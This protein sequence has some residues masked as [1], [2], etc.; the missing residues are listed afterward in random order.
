MKKHI[1]KMSFILL[2]L[3]CMTVFAFGTYAAENEIAGATIPV[4]V[5]VSGNEGIQEGDIPS[6][7]YR[8]Q[9]TALNDAPMPANDVLTIQGAGSSAF[10]ISY[11]EVGVYKYKVVQDASG[12]TGENSVCNNRGHY[13]ESVFYV[14][15]TV[16]N[17]AGGGYSV[18]VSAHKD[19]AEGTKSDIAY[20]NTYDPVAYESLTVK[21]TWTDHTSTRPD[22]IQ[23]QLLDGE[24]VV[25]T[26]ELT[27][28]GGWTYTWDQ[29]DSYSSHSWSVKELP[30]AGYTAEYSVDADGN[31]VIHNT[32]KVG[33]TLIQTG[34]LNWP[35]PVMVI[36]GL[37]LI[38]G[39]TFVLRKNSSKSSEIK[40]A[41]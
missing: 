27:A 2:A 5:S 26:V 20:V 10:Q 6:E 19:G 28:A 12:L 29:L 11:S 7:T 9:I 31:H 39:G 8:F 33:G 23:V 34:Q 25:Q 24:E 13:D 36:L 3:L 32:G 18:V 14:T 35:I 22:A 21:K 30:V 37:F 15:V 4:S 40:G 17:T 16:T 41:K 1:C 38:L